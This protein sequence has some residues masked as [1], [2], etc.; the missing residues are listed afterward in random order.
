MFAGRV[1]WDYHRSPPVNSPADSAAPTY[2]SAALSQQPWTENSLLALIKPEQAQ[3]QRR[4]QLQIERMAVNA[5]RCGK[6]A[7]VRKRVK[8][9]SELPMM[10]W[11]PRSRGHKAYGEG[12]QLG[13]EREQNYFDTADNLRC[14][15]SLCSQQGLT[16]GE[17]SFLWP[18]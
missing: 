16:W 10:T 1:C 9:S 7:N 4:L 12:T 2:L 3:P 18:Q 8:G 13:N 11:P 15:W 17:E 14:L 5:G 6:E